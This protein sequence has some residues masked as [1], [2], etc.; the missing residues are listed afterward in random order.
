[1]ERCRGGGE[2]LVLVVDLR[3]VDA[4]GGAGIG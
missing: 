2:V 3:D 4:T 1:M